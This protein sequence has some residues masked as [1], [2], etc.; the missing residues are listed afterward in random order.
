MYEPALRT[1]ELNDNST[2][3]DHI[4]AASDDDT[5]SW[6][7]LGWVLIIVICLAVML[8][9]F[10]SIVINRKLR[11]KPFN[12]Y[13]VYLIIPDLIYSGFCGITCLTNYIYGA[14]T[15][16]TM[17]SFQSVYL[18]YGITSN[19]WL[20]ALV[21]RQLYQ[22]LQDSTNVRRY[23]VPTLKRVTIE[24]LA[25]YLYGLVLGLLTLTE[26]PYD[27]LLIRG[28]A[29]L[30]ADYNRASSI[31]LYVVAMP[32]IALLPCG[33]V[34]Y[35]CFDIYRHRLLPPN[36]KRRT[37]VIYFCRV[38]VIFFVMWVPSLVA[39]FVIGP[40]IGVWASW[41]AG[42]WTHF[43][44]LASAIMM[45]LKK[46]IRQEFVA[47]VTCARKNDGLG[48]PDD[49]D[50]IQ[51]ASGDTMRPSYERGGHFSTSINH[52]MS[53]E[54]RREEDGLI[55]EDP[56][57]LESAESHVNEKQTSNSSSSGIR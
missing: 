8:P 14:Y 50:D 48:A 45:L 10:V 35:I 52:G 53:S 7:W 39:I 17:C 46:D 22:M 54:E 41:V 23:V 4:V 26:L 31:F 16:E 38:V 51:P 3:Y 43:Q 20:N 44:G 32:L 19:A 36:D 28:Q 42:S 18:V 9:L 13:L 27:A 57:A 47:F 11:S 2:R 34:A 56:E 12:L 40:W 55:E 21:V 6:Q 24:S 1:W 5:L 49:S 25:I 37:L 33:Y 15:S 29:C 30:P